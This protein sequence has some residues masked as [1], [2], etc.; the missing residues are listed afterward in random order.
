MVAGVEKYYQIVK[1]YRD[2]DQRGD[3]Q[4]EFTQL[5]I[6]MSFLQQ[7]GIISLLETMHYKFG[8]DIIPGKKDD[9]TVSENDLSRIY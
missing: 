8:R 1:C 5:D 6:E 9:K 4:P 2:E 3:R 7:E